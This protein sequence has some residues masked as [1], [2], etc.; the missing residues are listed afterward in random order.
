MSDAPLTRERFYFAVAAV[1]FVLA[2]MR[3]TNGD[4]GVAAALAVIGVV[5]LLAGLRSRER[6]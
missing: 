3:V 1:T 2:S 4:A 5:L 6:G